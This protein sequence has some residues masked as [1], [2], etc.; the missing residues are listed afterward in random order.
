LDKFISDNSNPIIAQ[1]IMDIFEIIFK[2]NDN[3]DYTKDTFILGDYRTQESKVDEEEVEE[4]SDAVRMIDELSYKFK[5]ISKK[6]YEESDKQD[7]VLSLKDKFIKSYKEKHEKDP[8]DTEVIDY[9][10]EQENEKEVDEDED[11]DEFIMKEDAGSDEELEKG[12]GYG[13]MPQGGEGGED[14]DY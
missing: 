14:G 8:T 2:D 3:L 4:K 11:K 12:V 7:E 9:L 13:E 5:K 6:V 10:E 1:F